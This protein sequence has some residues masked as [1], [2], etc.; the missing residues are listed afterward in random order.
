MKL[1]GRVEGL[2]GGHFDGGKVL[3]RER[4]KW[5]RYTTLQWKWSVQSGM[6][7]W[8]KMAKEVGIHQC[9]FLHPFS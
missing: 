4:E 9:K 6:G 1:E 8:R 3:E 7:E 5:S 2:E